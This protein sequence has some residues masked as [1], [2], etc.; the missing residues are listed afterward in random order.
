MPHVTL[1]IIAML[2]FDSARDK[3]TTMKS[4]RTFLDELSF[5]VGGRH[6][7]LGARYA[8]PDE[9][10][11]ISKTS[12]TKQFIPLLIQYMLP[13]LTYVFQEFMANEQAIASYPADKKESSFF[14]V[15][16]LF[17]DKRSFDHIP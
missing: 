3:T 5:A 1:K 2:I 16:V 11:A 14:S 9:R 10:A 12:Q 7:S 13:C 6:F 17:W 15:I 8:F 4:H